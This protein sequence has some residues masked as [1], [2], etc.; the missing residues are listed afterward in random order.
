MKDANDRLDS[1]LL[2]RTINGSK[3]AGFPFV[4]SAVFFQTTQ[5]FKSITLSSMNVSQIYEDRYQYCSER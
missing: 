5:S 2:Q 1:G 3:N 4:L